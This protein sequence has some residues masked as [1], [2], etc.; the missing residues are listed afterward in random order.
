VAQILLV[1]LE[2][3]GEAMLLWLSINVGFALR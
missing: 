1:S 3:A 2:D